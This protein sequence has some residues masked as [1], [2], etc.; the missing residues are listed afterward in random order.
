[1]PQWQ[2]Q[3][4]G[5]IASSIAKRRLRMAGAMRQRLPCSALGFIE[6]NNERVPSLSIAFWRACRRSPPAAKLSVSCGL[7]AA[8]SGIGITF[9]PSR[10]RSR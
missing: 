10:S 1:L 5:T 9:A 8:R 6:V 2:H 3:L 4:A 7:H